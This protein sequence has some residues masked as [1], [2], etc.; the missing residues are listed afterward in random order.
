M[1]G[2]S[3]DDASLDYQLCYIGFTEGQ[4]VIQ[5]SPMFLTDEV[6]KNLSGE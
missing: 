5:L 3:L 4:T 2:A 1:I 6:A